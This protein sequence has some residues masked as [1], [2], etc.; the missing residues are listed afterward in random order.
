MRK[1]YFF[2]ITLF[3]LSIF[4]FIGSFIY[5]DKVKRKVYF[6]KVRL[7]N[8]DAGSI[9]IDKF[10]TEDK[11]IYKSYS[12][13][14]FSE[15][16]TASVSRIV[17]D[18][19]YNIES[20]TKEDLQNNI[21]RLFYIEK[22]GGKISFLSRFYS[23]FAFLNN[24]P[25]RGG[26]FIFDETSPVTYLPIIE[27]YDWKIGRSQGF[28]IIS[29][30]GEFMPPATGMMTLTSINDEYLKLERRKIKAEHLLVKIRNHPE[31]GIWVAKSDRT[32]LKLEIPKI[33]LVVSRKFKPPVKLDKKAHVVTGDSYI[34]R[35]VVFNNKNIRLSGTLTIPNGDGPFPS[36]LL[37]WGDGPQDRNYKGFFRLLAD[38]LT[39]NGF[40]VLT[41]DKRGVGES[42]GDASTTTD[43]DIAE[44]IK[45]A[46]DFLTSQKELDVN[47]LA[48]VTHHHGGYY[49]AKFLL[50]DTRIR[51]IVMLSAQAPVGYKYAEGSDFFKKL[52]AKNR[53]SEDF[54]NLV[55][56]TLKSTEERARNS[57]HNWTYILLKRCFLKN[58]KN[59]SEED[60]GDVFANIKIPV[61]IINGKEDNG[62][63]EYFTMV[64]KKSLEKAG[65][66]DFISKN[67]ASMGSFLGKR[68]FDGISRAYHEPDKYVM[69]DMIAWLKEK[70]LKEDTS[71]QK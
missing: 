54:M 41:F 29:E 40:C 64:I 21:K 69:D 42:G 62:M 28:N 18:T 15:D 44:D 68:V 32:L 46:I 25:V 3:I 6:Y 11:I 5:L 53:W 47:R 63:A 20:Y 52:M 27:N 19:K 36:I 1:V 50:T 33:G 39:K 38:Y 7:D 43:N 71:P 9:R 12:D 60:L 10:I 45:C 4:L 30:A 34:S 61:L 8:K 16:F 31:G 59:C 22:E 66:G 35:D 55:Q 56:K 24:I 13:M 51:A 48:L 37:I 17:L 23:R 2:V 49:A 70:I 67:Y 14:P 57:K 58:I 65:R 26:S